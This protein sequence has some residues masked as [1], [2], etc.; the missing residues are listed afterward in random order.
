MLMNKE[1]I[2]FNGNNLVKLLS[3]LYV[4]LLPIG[5][6]LAGI[7]GSIS[8]MNYIAV[9]ILTFGLIVMLS[10]GKIEINKKIIPTL[11][12]FFYTVISVIWAV[13]SKFNWYIATNLLNGALFF[14]LNSIRWS[15]EDFDKLRRCFF[16]SQIIV[17]LVVIRN[18][19]TLF[20]YR[21]NITVVSSIGISDFACGLSLLLAFWMQEAAETKSRIRRILSYIFVA[22]NFGIIIM[23][24][25]RGALVMFICMIGMWILIGAYSRK[26][27]IISIIVIV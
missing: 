23:A 18:L 11:I 25:S 26:A 4:I 14:V 19:S 22:S 13:N 10:S 8:L 6:G 9:L 5:T 27:K 12:Y 21:L 2:F 3:E 15:Q 17:I 7:I 20:V 16:V 1:T 24:G